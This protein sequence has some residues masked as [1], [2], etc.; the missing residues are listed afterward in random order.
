M[1]WPEEGDGS[2]QVIGAQGSAFEQFVDDIEVNVIELP[3]VMAALEG[4]QLGADECSAREAELH[5]AAYA[6]KTELPDRFMYAVRAIR[7]D[8]TQ[9]G[10][11]TECV[12]D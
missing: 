2:E 5:G 11:D 8:F 9:E 4:Q 6:D 1:P 7:G 12:E 3:P 10:V